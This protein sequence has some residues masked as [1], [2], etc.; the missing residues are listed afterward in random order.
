[1]QELKEQE[2]QHQKEMDEK[3]EEHQ[4][5]KQE[6]ET[7]IRKLVKLIDKLKKKLAQK[8][9][10]NLIVTCLLKIIVQ[11]NWNYALSEGH[12]YFI[13]CQQNVSNEM[14]MKWSI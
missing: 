12:I 13:K 1:M 14:S 11:L 5:E 3:E 8:G 4:K 2:R 9:L 6:M 7:D 10:W